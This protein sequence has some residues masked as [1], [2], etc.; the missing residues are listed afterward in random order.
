M[1]IDKSTKDDVEYYNSLSGDDIFFANKLLLLK[2]LSLSDVIKEMLIKN[3]LD[4]KY[5]NWS[6]IVKF[7]SLLHDKTPSY[8]LENI[9]LF[10]DVKNELLSMNSE[11][12]NTILWVI[13]VSKYIKL[14][15]IFREEINNLVEKYPN[16]LFIDIIDDFLQKHLK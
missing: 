8:V 13:S 9:K 11:K 4:E 14:P 2:N 16:K 10:D 5:N 6:N 7:S 1:K 3:E 15:Y 12:Q